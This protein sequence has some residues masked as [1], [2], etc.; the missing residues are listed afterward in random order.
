MIKCD[1]EALL[2]DYVALLF[3]QVAAQVEIRKNLQ[4][5]NHTLAGWSDLLLYKVTFA[6]KNLD[7]EIDL[8]ERIEKYQDALSRCEVAKSV[9]EEKKASIE[10][11]R[12]VCS[13]P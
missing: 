7:R 1:N 10:T 11:E 8:K 4:M 12:A 13:T 9:L 5:M 6:E 3:P 2:A